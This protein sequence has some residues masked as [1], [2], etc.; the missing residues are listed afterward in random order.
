MKLPKE[1]RDKMALFCNVAPECIIE[2]LDAASLYEVPLMLENGGLADIACKS[3][4]IEARKPDLVDW[5]Q[6]VEQHKLIQKGEN[7]VK[8]GLVGKYVSLR[9]AYISIAEALTHAGIANGVNVK[10]KWIDSEKIT[11]EN[12]KEQMSDL[13]GVL[14]P[15]GVGDRGVEGK[16]SAIRYAREKNIPFFGI[17]LGMQLAVI[18]FGRNVLKLKDA[19]SIEINPNTKN[20]V[21]DVMPEQK[22][23]DSKGATMR[24]GQYACNLVEGTRASKAY[25]KKNITERHRH[26]YEFNNDYKDAYSRAGM[27]FSGQSP[28]ERLVEIIELAELDWFVGVQF[29]PEF[30]SRPNKVHPLFRDF[31]N[32]VKCKANSAKKAKK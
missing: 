14:V 15:G 21:I 29:H 27:V 20:P 24:L 26:R 1:L 3:L 16:I 30:K 32:A 19:G 25:Q 10:I 9:D 5:E 23:A 31:V 12:I 28:D 22:N 18:E 13:Q 2:N 6:L 7:S 4:S 8:I 11:P 17:S